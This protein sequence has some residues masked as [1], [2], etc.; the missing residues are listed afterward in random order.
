MFNPKTNIRISPASR[1]GLLVLAV[2]V[3]A[4]AS[5]LSSPAPAADA[6]NSV[7]VLV[8]PATHEIHGA[9]AEAAAEIHEVLD[10]FE[11]TGLELPMLRIYV[12]DSSEECFEN[13]GLFG[14]DGDLHRVDICMTHF[15]TIG[16]ELAHAWERH[17]MEDATR[18]MYMDHLGIAE[19]NNHDN[20][21]PARAMEQ[22][23]DL[24]EWGIRPEPLQRISAG[25]YAED[26]V[27]FE[28]LTGKPT[29]RIAHWDSAEP[30][31]VSVQ[32]TGPVEVVSNAVMK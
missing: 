6:A 28:A 8:A 29:L 25:H 21:A 32:L 23:A 31:G 24:I 17:V 20:N 26:I 5:L 3:T 12:H 7:T 10:R 9:T 22:A 14:R 4:S 13:R 27:L 19:W 16:H 1:K 30:P 2:A 18:K 11:E 15:V